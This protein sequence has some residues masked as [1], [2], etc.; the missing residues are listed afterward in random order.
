MYLNDVFAVLL[1]IFVHFIDHPFIDSS[2]ESFSRV[3]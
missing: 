3:A 1:S 2:F